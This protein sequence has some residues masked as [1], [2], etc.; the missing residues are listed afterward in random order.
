MRFQRL[1][2]VGKHRQL[3]K[4]IGQWLI[5]GRQQEGCRRSKHVFVAVA[6]MMTCLLTILATDTRDA[7]PFCA[8]SRAS[9]DMRG[10][11]GRAFYEEY[12]WTLAAT[13]IPYMPLITLL[14]YQCIW[15]DYTE[16]DKSA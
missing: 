4:K 5:P 2:S 8:T 12:A 10:E 9:F 15:E 7:R 11:I 14:V 16:W 3:Q 13:N 1:G 6:N